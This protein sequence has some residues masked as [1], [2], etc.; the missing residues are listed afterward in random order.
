MP[1]RGRQRHG[2]AI[3]SLAAAA[4]IAAGCQSDVGTAGC[5][6][7]TQL[8]LPGSPLTLLHGVRLDLVGSKYALMGYDSAQN[9]VR[10]AML[11]LANE[12]LEP[13][14]AYGLPPGAQDPLFAMAAA[15]P[16]AQTP[17][18]GDAILTG[19][20]PADTVLIGYVDRDSTGTNGELSMMPVPADGSAPAGPPVTILE[21]PGGIPPASSLAMVSSRNGVHAGLAWIDD[22]LHHVMYA[23]VDGSG[24]PVVSPTP[25]GSALPGFQLLAFTPGKSDVTLLY[26]SDDVNG[27]NVT[28]PGWIIAEGTEAGGIVSTTALVFSRQ[29]ESPGFLTPTADGYALAWQEMSGAWMGVYTGTTQRVLGPYEFAPSNGFGGSA[30]QPPLVG[31]ATFG[32]DFGAVFQQPRDAELWRLDPMGA[33]RSGALIFPSALGNIGRVS[34]AP[35]PHGEA[36]V[37]VTYADYSGADATSD[38][39][40]DRLFLKATCY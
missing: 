32:S 23:A 21:F 17:G 6:I 27:G 25:V 14:H 24:T 38:L 26:H 37:V 16:P 28:G 31:L 11:D 10:W 40:G 35:P 18:G 36:G 33:R 34:V 39:G 12:T 13:E 2:L 1:R 19:P 15:P 29:P 20:V 3:C 30:L 8:T 4:V 7:S 22:Q 5:Q 9:A